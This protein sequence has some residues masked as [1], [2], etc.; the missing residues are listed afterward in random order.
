MMHVWA[1]QRHYDGFNSNV[2]KYSANDYTWMDNEDEI[3]DIK[4]KCNAVIEQ[5]GK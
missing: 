2:N 3:E 4:P 5:I 1:N